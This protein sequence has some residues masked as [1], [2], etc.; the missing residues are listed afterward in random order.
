MLKIQLK[1]VRKF[2]TFLCQLKGANKYALAGLQMQASELGLS[3][4]K[5]PAGSNGIGLLGLEKD[6]VPE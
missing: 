6:Q 1:R 5:M 2:F 4:Q 3:T